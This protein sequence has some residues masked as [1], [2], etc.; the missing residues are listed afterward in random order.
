MKLLKKQVITSLQ[1][2]FKPLFEAFKLT[3]RFK[4]NGIMTAYSKR[5]KIEYE[6]LTR[7][8]LDAIEELTIKFHHDAN[9]LARQIDTL[10]PNLRVLNIDTMSDVF[11]PVALRERLNSHI[12]SQ[13]YE[14]KKE[15]IVDRMNGYNKLS[16]EEMMHILNLKHLEELRIPS[17]THIKKLDL[18]KLS[19]LKVLLAKDC[20]NLKEIIGLNDNLFFINYATFDFTGCER[21]DDKTIEQF[22]SKFDP[23]RFDG[24]ALETGHLFLPLTVMLRKSIEN[25]Q[26]FVEFGKKFSKDAVLF[27]QS[28]NGV[29]L[30][31]YA[32]VVQRYCGELDKIIQQV[33]S[34]ERSNFKNVLEL[35]KWVTDNILYDEKTSVLEQ[36][37]YGMLNKNSETAR[38]ATK[39]KSEKV[40]SAVYALKNKLG[41]CVAI[42][43]LFGNLVYRSGF[44]E[45]VRQVACSSQKTEPYIQPKFN[46]QITAIKFK[47][48]GQYYFDATNDLYATK[49][50]FFAKN[51][52]EISQKFVLSY[53]EHFVDN[54]PS[55]YGQSQLTGLEQNI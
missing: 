17:Q 36:Q 38:V 30:N 45:E 53:R 25:S 23:S 2:E 27:S 43:E 3:K 19:K 33:C 7:E 51:K 10:L 47:N 20:I 16:D 34:P 4:Q 55:L 1:P 12:R 11:V 28:S 6:I 18:S 42:S 52:Q 24:Q 40:R 22:A 14:A 8:D 44:A 50:R 48:V 26:N 49:P 39:N 54:A 35:Y 21:L 15:E 9:T 32:S 29:L 41:V 5:R 31:H 37:N 13:K 46:H